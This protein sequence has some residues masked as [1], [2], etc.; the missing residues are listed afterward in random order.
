M[1]VGFILDGLQSDRIGGGI[2]RLS[3]PPTPIPKHDPMLKSG[4]IICE[5]YR[6]VEQLGRRPGRQTWRALDLASLPET[7]GAASGDLNRHASGS[8]PAPPGSPTP[9]PAEPAG[10]QPTIEDDPLIGDVWD[11]GETVISPPSQAGAELAIAPTSPNA[12]EATPDEAIPNESNA[13]T[14]IIKLLAF[15]DEIDWGQ[16][17][18]FER[19]AS[20][21][22]DLNHPALPRYRDSFSIEDRLLWFC[23]VQDD[24]PGQSL[25]QLLT[26]GGPSLEEAQLR[27]WAEALL[28]IL[29]YL[30]SQS[31]PILHRDIKPSNVIWGDDQQIYLIDL[32]AAQNYA[33]KASLGSSF[34]VVGTYGYAPL[35]QFGGRSVPASDLY[36]LGATLI[37]LLTGIA[38][39]DLPQENLRLQFEAEISAGFRRW[40]LHLLEPDVQRRMPSAKAALMALRQLSLTPP[41]AETSSEMSPAAITAFPPYDAR[42]AAAQ[43]SSTEASPVQPGGASTPS[44]TER[45]SPTPPQ[46][47]RQPALAQPPLPDQ[48]LSLEM[49][50]TPGAIARQVS[51]MAAS[52][53]ERP[54][55]NPET[56]APAGARLRLKRSPDL[57]LVEM[58]GEE[59]GY[60]FAVLG[61]GFSIWS[62]LTGSIT[63]PFCLLFTLLGIFLATPQVLRF[64]RQGRDIRFSLGKQLG[65]YLLR[66]GRRKASGW[67]HQVFHTV[68]SPKRNQES[69]RL[70]GS[71]GAASPHHP[72]NPREQRTGFGSLQSNHRTLVIQTQQRDIPISTSLSW[73]ESTWLV[74]QIYAW[75]DSE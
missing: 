35:E 47:L 15:S 30:H 46:D 70:S 50:N 57:L 40:L 71:R 52:V 28:E 29:I 20:V 3:M 19:E 1:G 2:I 16:V 48:P 42:Q 23:L 36:A 55:L 9:A 69:G 73:Q 44:R 17:K 4:Q 8:D 12:N 72:G 7:L 32:G 60:V 33:A 74:N 68:Q 34:T 59:L 10:T 37:H 51:P 14:V 56:L 26:G 43:A 25:D 66:L 41:S 62:L 64:E 11:S 27:L 38:P 53:M 63:L 5:R 65:G 39:A 31:P 61:V 13:E 45:R 58:P 24:I 54:Q 21:L 75:F 22:Q 49:S 18:L 6:L 67:V